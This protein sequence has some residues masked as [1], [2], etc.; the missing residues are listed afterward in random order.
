MQMLLSPLLFHIPYI[1]ILNFLFN[2]RNSYF[3]PFLIFKHHFTTVLVQVKHYLHSYL[4]KHLLVCGFKY[5][6]RLPTS[7][8]TT[9]VWAC[10][11]VCVCVWV[12]SYLPDRPTD[13]VCTATVADSDLSVGRAAGGTGS[14]PTVEVVVR[15]QHSRS[16]NSLQRTKCSTPKSATQVLRQQQV[17][18]FKFFILKR[19]I[20]P[21]LGL[22]VSCS[23]VAQLSKI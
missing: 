5:A 2:V 13:I 18:I 3:N 15:S 1:L 4:L 9:Q 6:F 21:P 14:G 19:V 22:Y 12:L 11:C 10:G 16:G 8:N 23:V 20:S 17:S 7:P